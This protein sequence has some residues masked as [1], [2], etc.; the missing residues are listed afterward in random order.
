[1]PK[2]TMGFS[3]CVM[4]SIM[5]FMLL[6]LFDVVVYDFRMDLVTCELV[7]ILVVME[8]YVLL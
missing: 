8:V 6:V 1:M 4:I 3:Q 2:A 7:M 5:S